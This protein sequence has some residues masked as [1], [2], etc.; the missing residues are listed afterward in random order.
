MR[1]EKIFPFNRIV[2]C[3]TSSCNMERVTLWQKKEIYLNDGNKRLLSY[4]IKVYIIKV[5]I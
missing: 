5:Y 3:S 2:I 1:M 4:I